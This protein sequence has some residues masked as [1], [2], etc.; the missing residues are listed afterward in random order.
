[1]TDDT[2]TAGPGDA[3]DLHALTGAYALDALDD[4]ERRTFERH[5]AGCAAC[6]EEVRGFRETAARLA[7]GVTL[8]P[9][10]AMRDRVLAEVRRTPQLPPLQ[11]DGEQQDA[12]GRGRPPASG[13]TWVAAAAVAAVLALGGGTFGAVEWRAAQ[14]ARARQDAAVAREQR[15]ATVLSD[16][17]RRLVSAPVSSGGTVTLAVAGDRAVVLTAGV[18]GLPADRTYQLWVVRSDGIRS[19]GLGPAAADAAGSW[20]RPV[21][22]I[23]PG[24]TVAVSV[25]PQ[26]G[27]QQPTTEPVA[28]VKV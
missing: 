2:T 26:G 7:D 15:I 20:A 16:P 14:D 21:E 4:L 3:A 24:D 9:A 19:L 5:L 11:R 22:G 27:S 17:A 6:R 23:R 1:M 12:A 18:A 28:A 10:G 8:A 13:R 25:E